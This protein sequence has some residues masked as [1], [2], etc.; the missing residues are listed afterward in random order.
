MKRPAAAAVSLPT[1]LA[2]NLINNIFMADVTQ[3]YIDNLITFIDNAEDP[4]TV[5]N[6]IVAAVLDYLNNGL[7]NS[8][9]DENSLAEET[10]ARQG[11]D[12]LLQTAINGLQ[13]AITQLQARDTELQSQIATQ[14]TAINTLTGANASEAIESFNE[15]IAFLQGIEDTDSLEALLA[16]INSSITTLQG[17]V[18]DVEGSASGNAAAILAMQDGYNYQAAIGAAFSVADLNTYQK[19]G[20]YFIQKGIVDPEPAI[21]IVNSYTTAQTGGDTVR[22]VTQYLFTTDAQK[23][24]TGTCTNG[25]VMTWTEWAQVGAKGAGNILNIDELYPPVTGYH[26]IQTAIE[27]VDSVLRCRGRIITFAV[28]AEEWAS[29]QF[30]GSSLSQWNTATAWKSYMADNSLKRITFNGVPHDADENGNISINVDT[31][32]VDPTLSPTSTNPVQNKAITEKLNQLEGGRVFSMDVEQAADE[33][34]V[35]L[36]LL[37]QTG[38]VIAQVDIPTGGGGGGGGGEGAVTTKIVITASVDNP[39][40][41]EGGNALLSYFFDHQYS[42][43]E[44]AGQTTG[45]KATITVTVKRGTVTMLETVTHDVMAGTY[46]LD[47]SPYLRA[48]TTDVYVV[49]EVTDTVTGRQQRKQAYVS[50]RA[51]TLSLSSTYNLANSIANGGYLASDT[52]NIPFAV[53]GSGTKEVNLYIDGVQSDSRVITKSGTTNS[54]FQITGNS[55]AEG[56][57]T[58][59][60]VAEMEASETLTLTS[61]SIYIDILRAY[62]NSTPHAFIGIKASFEDGRIFTSNHLTPVLEVVQFEQLSF[63]FVVYDPAQTP[64]E[65]DIYQGGTLVSSITPPRTVQNYSNRYTSSGTVVMQFVAAGTTYNFSIEVTASGIDLAEVVDSRLLKLSAAGRSN[66]EADPANWIYNNISTIFNGF[67]WSSDGWDGDA[68]NL[69]NGANIEICFAPF[70]VDRTANGFTAEMEVVCSNVI[71]REGAVVSC[72]NGGIGFSMTTEEA[73]IVTASGKVVS[74]KFAADQPIKVAFVATDKA[75]TKL[76]MIYVNGIRCGA[77][78]YDST[79]SLLQ[80]FPEHIKVF[81]EAADVQLRNL[82]IYGRAL[83]DDEIL[84]NYMVDRLTATEMVTLY[85]ANDVMKENGDGVDIDKLRAQGKAVMRVVGDVELVNETNDKKFEV[86]VDVYYYSPYGAAYDFVARNVGFRIQGTSST[87]YPR[88]NYRIYFDR[89]GA[90]LEVNGVA[91]PSMEYAFKPGARP[92]KIWCLKAD[93]SDSSSVLNSGAARIVNDVYKECDWLTP[94]QAAYNGDYDVRVGVD[95]I[96]MDLF[97][98]NEGTGVANY[99]GKY[100]FN[101]EKAESGIVYGFEGIE[102]YN[103]VDTLAGRRNPCICLEFLNNSAP[104][105]LFTTTDMT[106]FDAALEFRFKD[107]VKWATADEADKQAIERLWNWVY[108]CRNNYAKF[109]NEYTDYF[110][111]DSPFVWYL[112]TDYLMAVD[113]RV[114]NMMLATWDGLHWMFLPYDM[115]T[116]LGLRN[117]SRLVF[118]YLTMWD[119]W[120]A[121]QEAYAFAG[122]DSILWD[123]VRGCASK[124]RSVAT[125]LRNKMTL[126]MVRRVFDV[127]FMGNWSERIYN[128]DGEYKYIVPHLEMGRNYLY[129]LQGSRAAHRAYTLV[130]RFALLDAM[131]VAGTYRADAFS[132]YFAYRFSQDNRVVSI[133]T[134]ERY[135]YGYGYTNGEPTQIAVLAAAAGSVVT[136]TLATDLIVNDPQ[137]FYGASRIAELD[138]NDVAHAIVGTLN[139]NNCTRLTSLKVS[140]SQSTLTAILVSQCRALTNLNIAGLTG[141]TTLDL[142]K[143]VKLETLN[144]A[145]TALTGVTFASGGNLET[146]TLPATLQTLEL[147]YL[148]RLENSGIIMPSKD[149]ITRLVVDNCPLIDWQ[150][151]AGECGSLRYLR[152]TDIDMEGDGTLLRSLMTMQGVDEY[153]GNVQTCRLVGTYKLTQ[154]MSDEEYAQI[155]A[156]FPELNVKQPEWTIIKFDDTVSDPANI[157]NLDNGTG[158]DYGT[159]YVPSA[160]VNA[161][162]AARHRVI[163]KNTAEGVMTVCRLLDSDGRRYYDGTEANTKGFAHLEKEDEGDVMLW[164]PHRWQKGVDDFVNH[165]HYSCFSSLAQV[166]PAPGVKVYLQDMETTGGKVVRT[167]STYETLADALYDYVDFS[168]HEVSVAG[169]KRV[170][171]P[172]ISSTAYGAVFVDDEGN[173]LGRVSTS[174]VRMV[175]GDYLFAN[176]PQGA[177]KLVFTTMNSAA[178]SF[179]WLTNSLRIE[180]VEPDPVEVEPYL[181]GVYK[182][183]TDNQQIRSISDRTPTVSTT[184]TAW[185]N[186]RTQRGTGW[187]LID[188]RMHRDIANLFFAKYGTRNSQAKCGNGSGANTTKTGYTDALGMQDTVMPSNG[189][190]GGQYVNAEGNIATC[191]SINALGYENL[192]GNISEFCDG[193]TINARVWNVE[194]EGVR[195]YKA[196]SASGYI[197]AIKHGRYMDVIPMA[198]AGS[199]STQYCDSYTPSDSNS[200]VLYRSHNSATAEGGVSSAL[201]NFDAS[202]SN[203]YSG[204]RLAFRGRIVEASSV[205]AFLAAEMIS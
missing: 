189:G 59:Q 143:N 129:S 1:N 45:Q 205:A 153:G 164:E 195:P 181:V 113:N 93:F 100:N 188:Y 176:V 144:A 48:G 131:Y 68:L 44:D 149:A 29:Y 122:H 158:Y 199:S 110:I 121:S 23:F 7:K 57:H 86:R 25:G 174:D 38:G 84:N 147:R 69:K 96:P 55:L 71:N 8:T 42:S 159:D 49:A 156:H 97:Y 89:E 98:D 19:P 187:Q 66:R 30:R 10:A 111:N 50:V 126:E 5:T 99:L 160:H 75:G 133:T 103:D 193:V 14:Q 112:I 102:G 4:G 128:K 39:V 151:L 117:D 20:Y 12:S 183:N 107:G 17:R 198:T 101:N 90:S 27:A 204:S 162:L 36:S 157:T 127:E 78:D 2:N 202:Y 108:S 191:T 168:V 155:V 139:L 24:R 56:R 74:T 72:M 140:A 33:S 192:W 83:T 185:R 46:E 132:V 54:S 186:W 154:S 124:L 118:D 171:F 137:N 170:R 190:N 16:A 92:V 116:L 61:E 22:K 166:T 62:E 76:L 65:M 130:N 81:S 95:A 197:T 123:L 35:S 163:A 63:D 41:R 184:G 179:V 172:A 70:E 60:M 85:R 9:V 88:K 196:A 200:R 125:T 64:T 175:S 104:L 6:K 79:D 145:N 11:A 21:F 52:I 67:N 47:L 182:A 165:V 138:L 26:T 146:A 161:I 148:S 180:D 34:S 58:I 31:V 40:I 150:T 13:L 152:I 77:Q 141:F 178:F 119:T 80:G 94:P 134:S 51:L 15:V 142:S 203:A 91:V 87:T 106:N 37:N 53:S 105:G 136:L 18:T 135:Y 114:K 109:L 201:A 73:K 115:D 120:D 169:W 28:G 173:I 167:S 82:R 177:T 3:Q 43:G 194:G 32:E